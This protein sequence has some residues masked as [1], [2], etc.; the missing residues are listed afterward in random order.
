M[1]AITGLNLSDTSCVDSVK[2]NS[3]YSIRRSTTVDKTGDDTGNIIVFKYHNYFGVTQGKRFVLV[4]VSVDR[5]FLVLVISI[6]VDFVKIV[7]AF[8]SYN[9]R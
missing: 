5:R 3:D 2:I 6:A 4:L 8:C 9:L 1:C 7:T